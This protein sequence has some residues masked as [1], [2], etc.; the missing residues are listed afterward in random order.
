[1]LRHAR[2]NGAGLEVDGEPLTCERLKRIIED[3]FADHESR[4]AT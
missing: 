2:P 3:V 1:L 4:A